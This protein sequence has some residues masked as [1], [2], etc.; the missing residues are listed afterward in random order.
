MD[1]VTQSYNIYLQCHS[2][3]TYIH[4]PHIETGDTGAHQ[5]FVVHM[6]LCQPPIPGFIKPEDGAMEPNKLKIYVCRLIYCLLKISFRLIYI[7]EE[8]YTVLYL[9]LIDI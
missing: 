6:K 2:R 9:N 8:L 7:S 5:M 3:N 1:I 4:Y